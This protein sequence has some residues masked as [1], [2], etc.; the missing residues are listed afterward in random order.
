MPILIPIIIIPP[1]FTLVVVL[2]EMPAAQHHPDPW[3]LVLY[4]YNIFYMAF[5]LDLDTW[6]IPGQILT[7]KPPPGASCSCKLAANDLSRSSQ[8]VTSHNNP[9]AIPG[10]AECHSLYV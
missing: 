7:G 6:I 5:T 10:G 4:V 3:A 2:I 1:V 8:L 9:T